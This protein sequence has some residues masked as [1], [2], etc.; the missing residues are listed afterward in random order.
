MPILQSYGAGVQ[1]DVG[2]GAYLFVDGGGSVFR[3]AS[4]PG[5]VSG[6]GA[7]YS[8]GTIPDGGTIYGGFTLAPWL[9]AQHVTANQF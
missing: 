3:S 2:A 9:T 1:V 5:G 8:A 7:W 6:A 4:S